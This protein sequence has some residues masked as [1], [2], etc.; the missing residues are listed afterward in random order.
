[1]EKNSKKKMIALNIA[2]F[3]GSI[4]VVF[5]PNS[6][7]AQ[8]YPSRAIQIVV[9]WSAGDTDLANRLAASVLPTYLGQPVVVIN[10]PGAQAIVGMDFVAKAP[11]DGYTLIGNG[12]SQIIV[13]MIQKI[14]FSADAFIPLVQTTKSLGVIVVKKDAPWA[15]FKEFIMEAKKRPGFF[16]YGQPGVGSWHNLRWEAIKSQLEIDIVPVPFQGNVGVVTALLGGNI[17]IGLI[18]K[19][20]ALPHIMGGT[21]KS[22]AISE[23]DKDFPGTIT[24]EEQ[25][26]PGNFNT[27]RGI[28]GRKEIPQD[29][30]K[31]LEEAFAKMLV[32]KSFVY[33]VKNVGV[34]PGEF[35]GDRFRKFVSEEEKAHAKVVE[36]VFKKGK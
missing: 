23:K 18:E 27:W 17:H 20:S 5:S 10:K 16:T 30:L 7:Y 2:F 31:V 9:P 24:F 36:K 29:R 32:D 25:G 6:L 12:Q 19:A 21:L 8:D 13:P 15:N 3:I 11:P 14:P 34:F 35:V 1:M 22:L 28:F 26:I 33:A 4:F